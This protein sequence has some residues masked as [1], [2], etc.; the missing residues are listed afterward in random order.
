MRP[1]DA[2]ADDIDATRTGSFGEV[3]VAA[4]NGAADL[5]GKAHAV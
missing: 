1:A 5:C 2:A 3:L 4:A